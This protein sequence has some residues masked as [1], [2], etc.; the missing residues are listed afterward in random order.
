MA[1]IHNTKK[2]MPVI[3]KP[4]DEKNWLNH[5]PIK[6]FANPYEVSLVAKPLDTILNLFG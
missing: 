2:R 5:A 4:E 3:L 1:E 6:N